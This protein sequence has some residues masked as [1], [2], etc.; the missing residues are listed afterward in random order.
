MANDPSQEKFDSRMEENTETKNISIDEIFRP[1]NDYPNYEISNMGRLR[2]IK[3]K[4]FMSGNKPGGSLRFNLTNTSGSSM[5]SA[6]KL[7]WTHF[8]DRILTDKEEIDHINGDYYDNRITNLRIAT[9][10][11]NTQNRCRPKNNKSGIKGICWNKTNNS[12]RAEITYNGKKYTKCS[13]D[14]DELKNWRKCKEQEFWG[15]FARNENDGDEKY[16]ESSES[17]KSEELIPQEGEIFKPVPG[18]EQYQISNY[19]RCWSS[20][21]NKFLVGN[22]H[23]V[24]R[25]NGYLCVSLDRTRYPIS[26]L[27]M[28]VFNPNFDQNLAVDHIDGNPHNNRLDNLRMATSAQN[29]YNRGTP[30]TNTSGHKGIRW[31]KR[32]KSWEALIT[33]H[34]KQHSK[35]FGNDKQAAIAWRQEK[36]KELFAEFRRV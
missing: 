1:V 31:H 23:A 30:S 4:K 15:E 7:V 25:G 22:E 14:K 6:H 8:S 34:G 33:I 5:I 19:G 2:N 24:V 32:D 28:M 29:S 3:T 17:L 26:R 13:S 10:Q 21:S 16:T 12:W 18:Q 36:E 9:R 20:K 27:V 11:Q 35:Y